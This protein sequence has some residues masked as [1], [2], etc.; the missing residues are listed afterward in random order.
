MQA[1]GPGDE[2]A[3]GEPGPEAADVSQASP[4]TPSPTAE[5][6]LDFRE[7]GDHLYD[8]VYI[9]DGSGKTLYVNKSYQR[10]TGLDA[11]ELVGRRVQDLV[12]AG[13]Y[14]NAVTPEVLRQRKRVHSVGQSLRNGAKLLITGNPIFD[15]NGEIKLV[16]VIEREITDLLEMQIELEATQEK[17]RAVEAVEIRTRREVE[18]LRKQV[19]NANLVGVSPQIAG[20]LELVRR[21][22]DFDVTVLIQGETGVGKEV[23]ANEIHALSARKGRPFIKVNCAAM[24]AGLLESELFGY[25]RGAFTGAAPGGK[26]GLFELADHGT[27]LLDE[28]GDLPLELQGKLLRVIQHKEMTRVGG[29]RSIRLDVRII[30]ATNCDLRARIAQKQFREDLYYRLSVFPIVIAPLRERRDDV[31]VLAQHF[32]ERHNRKYGKA[33]RIGR[34]GA[35]LFANYPWPGNVRELQNVVERIVLIADAHAIVGRA[36]I[37]PLLNIGRGVAEGAEPSL[38]ARVEALE[39]AEIDRALRSYGSTRKAAAALGVDQSTIVKKAKRLGLRADDVCHR[40]D[41]ERHRRPAAES[42]GKPGI[43]TA[44]R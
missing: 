39:R 28:I 1:D 22:A 13:V 10:I 14:A 8:G 35:D 7:I 11:S 15:A 32:L 30:A 20:V 27:I 21:V 17:M 26:L 38:K 37:A 25:E 12:D 40:N 6:V 33:I 24:P 44:K 9:A 2:R 43:R 4:A 3:A 34:E 31:A 29:S 5:A 36:Q 16:A 23:V 41:D 19:M 42:G 18:H